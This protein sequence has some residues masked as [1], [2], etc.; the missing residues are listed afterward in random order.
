[1][2]TIY[3]NITPTVAASGAETS[4]KGRFLSERPDM[5][6]IRVA[7][8]LDDD[9]SVTLCLSER[10]LYSTDN[11]HYPPLG[12]R[13]CV[14]Q[15]WHLPTRIIF[16]AKGSFSWKCKMEKFNEWDCYSKA[17]VEVA[18][19]T[20]V[21]WQLHGESGY[22]ARDVDLKIGWAHS[23]TKLIRLSRWLA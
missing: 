22:I 18:N 8:K 23:F 2:G 7:S 11:R 12:H 3:E 16:R 6:P 5:V 14:C 1:M 4:T 21:S 17:R 20:S 15:E 19:M 13:P 9:A 10:P